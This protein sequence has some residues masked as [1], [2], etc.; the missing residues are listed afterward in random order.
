MM[1]PFDGFLDVLFPPKM[2]DP[3]KLNVVDGREVITGD[4]VQ[5]YF[6]KQRHRSVSTFAEPSNKQ[7]SGYVKIAIE[8][9][10]F[11]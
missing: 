10:D 6:G 8:N 7:P 2:F 5:A 9:G 4:H 1:I 11:P 3:P